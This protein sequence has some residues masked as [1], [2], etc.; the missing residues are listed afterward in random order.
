M[1][2]YFFVF[3]LP[4]TD[5]LF[6]ILHCPWITYCY[7][8][9]SVVIFTH[10]V[11][12]QTSVTSMG[13]KNV[14]FN[15]F[16]VCSNYAIWLAVINLTPYN[17]IELAEGYHSIW[18]NFYHYIDLSSRISKLFSVNPGFTRILRRPW[19]QVGL[20]RL[21]ERIEYYSILIHFIY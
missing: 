8:V 9:S 17:N 12:S 2:L 15:K 1:I 4:T 20:N 6:Y 13:F 21:F 3:I 11:K 19:R 5:E 18:N 7:G 10:V 16:K 14:L